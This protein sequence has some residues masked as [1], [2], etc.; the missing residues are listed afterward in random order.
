MYYDPDTPSRRLIGGIMD[1]Y[2]LVNVVHNDYKQPSAI[3][4]PFWKAATDFAAKQ[5]SLLNGSLN[6]H[7]T[8]GHAN[9]HAN[10][11]TSGD[12]H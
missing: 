9:G 12:A 5:P 6:G 10:G 3:F 11:H 8:N 1:S 7:Q 4:E 2:L